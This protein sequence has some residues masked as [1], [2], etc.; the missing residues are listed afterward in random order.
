MSTSSKR[1]RIGWLLWPV[2]L[3]LAAL[4]LGRAAPSLAIATP[5]NF[6]ITQSPTGPAT[7]A[8]GT[9]VT[10]TVDVTPSMSSA[11]LI[12]KGTLDPSLGFSGTPFSGGYAGSC[13]VLG[14]TFTCTLGPQ[15][16]GPLTTLT[17]NT[18]V[19]NVADGTSIAQGA[20][21]FLVEDGSADAT[22]YSAPA[23]PFGALTVQNASVLVATSGPAG[24]V[25]G[26]A[27][28]TYNVALTNNGSAATGAFTTQV[29]LNGGTVYN[30]NCTDGGSSSGNGTSTASCSGQTSLSAGGG[31][32]GATAMQVTVTANT[33]G[34]PFSMTATASI[35][36]V[37][38]AA[39]STL[40]AAT[41]VSASGVSNNPVPTLS[42]LSPSS[43]ALGSNGFTLT[44]NGGS[45]VSGAQVLW[46]GSPRTTTF[47]NV[48]QLT[49]NIPASDVASGTSASV[50]VSN[51][52][53]GGGQSAG[54]LPFTIT[55]PAN[56]VP[57]LTALV[58]TSAAVGAPAFTLAVNGSNFVPASVVQWN[59]SALATTFGTSGSLSATVP[60][61]DL[62][63]AGSFSITV[64]TP[65]PGGGTSAALSFLVTTAA[66]IGQLQPASAPAGSPQL[67]LVVVG[68][69]FVPGAVVRWDG[70]ALA[71]SFTSNSALAAVVPAAN[72]VS[73][74]THQVTVLN[75]GGAS[76]STA[77]TFTV[78]SNAVKLGFT[79]QPATGV[80]STALPAQPVVAIQDAGGNTITSDSTTVVTLALVGG[81]AG[82]ALTCG[83]T[84]TGGLS[85]TA[86]NGLATFT[87][88]KVDTAATG[89][90]IT[91]TSVPALTSAT[92]NSFD[93]TAAP[94]V[95]TSQ[96]V[97]VAPAVGV[98]TPRSRLTFT[99]TTGTLSPAP[100]AVTFVI[101][102]TS[103]NDYWDATNNVWASGIVQNQSVASATPGTWVL[104]ITGEAR[105]Q[106]VNTSV[107]VTAYASAGNAAYIS[108][109]APT[110]AIR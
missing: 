13:S 11:A 5:T 77:S 48:N 27:Q 1:R 64:F 92:S 79:T 104:A 18:V 98:L 94:P 78:S 61:G 69:N 12:V 99:A 31:G 34:S 37:L 86:V 89:Y 7:V 46:N 44:V 55:A 73:A 49:A 71:T 65:S 14:H 23:A 54:S 81:P 68:S 85:V 41:A 82:A 100:T 58:Q 45:F 102:R 30:V 75:P 96:L 74:G 59:G 6:T 90:T 107:I 19:A 53:P 9:T 35:G 47:V 101:Q 24:P 97:V 50:A 52:A 17:V 51:P 103:D 93:I 26:G 33:S 80:A 2:A 91:A 20:N 66:T 56:P 8:A 57:V 40:V 76:A 108:A 3:L 88:C 39:G 43:A 72:L 62:V 106:F 70:T 67:S 10:Y 110:I 29:V 83:G 109:A 63:S 95:S 38:T 32:G 25:A 105:R 15:G 42:S 4:A 28:A 36:T 21:S 87:A 60:A 16:T 22:P 84:G